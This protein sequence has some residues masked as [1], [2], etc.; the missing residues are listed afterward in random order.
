VELI[1]VPLAA[2]AWGASLQGPGGEFWTNTGWFML[3][4]S[5]VGLAFLA[6]GALAKKLPHHPAK[7]A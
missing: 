1:W 3:P 6:S 7:E 5:I 2:F 4:F